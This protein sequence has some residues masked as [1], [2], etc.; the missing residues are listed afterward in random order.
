MSWFFVYV[1]PPVK[2]PFIFRSAF[3]MSHFFLEITRKY[4]MKHYWM[5]T[6]G[7]V[8]KHVVII[9]RRKTSLTSGTWYGGS[10]YWVGHFSTRVPWNARWSDAIKKYKLLNHLSINL[11]IEEDDFEPPTKMSHAILA[12]RKLGTLQVWW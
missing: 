8:H 1:N 7:P 10:Y 11:L 4:L 12:T 5:T 9:C 6:L 2:F 3:E